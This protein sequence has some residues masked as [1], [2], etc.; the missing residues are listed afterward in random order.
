MEGVERR[1]KLISI[2]KNRKE[3]PIS[4]TELAKQ[5]GV[6]RQVIVQDIALLRAVNKN[7]LSTTKGYLLY[8]QEAE[9]VNRCFMVKHTNDLIEDELCTIVDHGGKVLDVIVLHDIYGEIRTDLIISNRK[10]VYDFVKKVNE[11]QTVPL[12]EL[13]DGTHLH[14]V[15]ADSENVLDNIEVALREKGYLI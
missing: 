8:Y 1:E 12:K 4:G 6:S 10:D 5:L 11:K 14:T 15:E 9:K 7:I 2:L 3:E 13:T